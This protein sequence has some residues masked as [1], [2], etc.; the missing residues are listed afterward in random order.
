MPKNVDKNTIKNL[1][2]DDFFSGIYA[3]SKAVN[4]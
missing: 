4:K 2:G 3:R 1:L